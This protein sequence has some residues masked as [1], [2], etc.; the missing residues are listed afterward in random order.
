M[1]RKKKSDRENIP[2]WINNRSSDAKGALA[3]KQ[4]VIRIHHFYDSDIESTSDLVCLSLK[5]NKLIVR[6]FHRTF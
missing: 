1:A 3:L 6:C 5:T 2:S 4:L